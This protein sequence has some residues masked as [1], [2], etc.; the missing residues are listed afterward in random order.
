M[1]LTQRPPRKAA[2]R[3]LAMWAEARPG[4]LG[5]GP[6]AGLRKEEDA[7][8][9]SFPGLC[10]RNSPDWLPLKSRR[11]LLFTTS[12]PHP[13]HPSLAPAPRASLSP[14]FFLRVFSEG[15]VCSKD[16]GSLHGGRS[17]GTTLLPRAQSPRWV[18]R[19]LCGPSP[20]PYDLG[21][22]CTSSSWK[23]SLL[24]SGSRTG[25]GGQ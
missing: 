12:A 9:G 22:P 5:E 4:H 7:G 1:P 21:L 19:P 24:H 13:L 11:E 2:P 6:A 16:S 18:T 14:T 3:S 23:W 25:S 15:E 8:T 10:P 20:R 17:S